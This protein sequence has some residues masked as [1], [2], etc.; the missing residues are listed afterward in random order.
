MRNQV[1]YSGRLLTSNMSD[2]E[3]E[4]RKLISVGY[5]KKHV[6]IDSKI[7]GAIFEDRMFERILEL[8]KASLA[9]YF[10]CGKVIRG[11][12]EVPEFLSYGLCPIH[13]LMLFPRVFPLQTRAL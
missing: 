8:R 5:R 13:S 3:S 7:C 2:E 12:S 11:T 1:P 10:I 6:G 4:A 9:L